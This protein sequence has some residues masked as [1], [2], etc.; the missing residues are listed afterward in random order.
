VN[1]VNNVCLVVAVRWPY[2]NVL[3]QLTN[4][5]DS[6]VARCIYFN[7]IHVLSSRNCLTA[8]TKI[9]GFT[10][11][12]IGALECFGVDASRTCFPNASGTGKEVSVAN[13]AGID[14]SGKPASNM[15][16][17]N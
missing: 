9:A 7:Y 12:P 10:G 16:L 2:S 3:S 17:A 1:F 15:F 13:A 5:I 14:R 11:F 8:F 4:F 6:S